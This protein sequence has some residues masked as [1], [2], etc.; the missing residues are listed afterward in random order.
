MTAK[1][2]LNVLFNEA[3]KKNAKWVYVVVQI[4]GNEHNEVI[5]NPNGNIAAKLEYYNKAYNDELELNTNNGIK[6]VQYGWTKTEL[7]EGVI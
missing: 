4:K 5:F 6:I 3:I 7:I 1:E 2:R